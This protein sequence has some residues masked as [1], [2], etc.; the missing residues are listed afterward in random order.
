MKLSDD[1]VKVILAE[2]SRK[3]HDERKKRGLSMA[4]LAEISN[5]SVSHISKVEAAQC[6]IGLKALLKIATALEMDVMELLPCEL[7]EENKPQ[8]NGERF[9]SVVAT[10]DQRTVEVVLD[11]SEYMTHLFADKLFFQEKK[12]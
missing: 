12:K 4:R 3:I 9:E 10:A 7:Q 8:T 6:E 5:L 2:V 11:M 1:E